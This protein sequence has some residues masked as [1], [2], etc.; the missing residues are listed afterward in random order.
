M[1]EVSVILPNYNHGKY[2]DERISSIINQTFQNFELIILDDHSTDNSKSIIEKYRSHP[3]ISH[4]EFNEVNSG[5]PFRQWNKGIE[6]SQG[7][8]IWIAE[9]DDFCKI[10][11]LEETVAK[12]NTFPSVGL[13]YTQ[14]LEL[15]EI[16]GK[17]Y[18]SFKDSPRFKQA[19][20]NS[21]FANGRIEVSEKLT[22]ENTIPNASGVLFRKSV[23][24]KV[25][26]ADESMN[27]CGD[28]FLWVKILLASD[29]Y[30]IAEPLNV[31]RL[32]NI[33]VRTRFSKVQTFIERMK[34]LRWMRDNGIKKIPA[35]ELVLIRNLFNS[36]KL[37]DLKKPVQMVMSDDRTGN[38]LFLMI[39]AFALSIVDRI[40]GKISRI[41]KTMNP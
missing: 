24:R 22:Y 15:D 4:I 25:G 16:S 6:I 27:L 1:I 31:F 32:T 37:Q 7:P 18:I 3:K 17:E 21:Y 38:K 10:N 9:S 29:I 8:L 40:T 33:S 28:W 36:F 11:F 30:F 23:F 13:V 34:I 19:F 14:S 35:K 26:G 12:M 39:P 2:L 41:Q 20:N 5:S